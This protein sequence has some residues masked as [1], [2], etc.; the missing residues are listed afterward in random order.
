MFVLKESVHFTKYFFYKNILLKIG[1]S[2][3]GQQFLKFYLSFFFLWTSIIVKRLFKYKWQWPNW[4]IAINFYHSYGN[5]LYYGDTLTISFI[6]AK[7]SYY[8]LHFFKT[9]VE[10]GRTDC[11]RACW[12]V[13]RTLS[14]FR[15]VHFLAK[16]YAFS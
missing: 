15:L 12:L 10:W 1:G 4:W 5:I 7:W 2:K 16:T 8:C 3:I 6:Y 11:F 13:G 14:F 9:E